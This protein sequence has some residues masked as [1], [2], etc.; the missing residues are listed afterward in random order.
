MEKFFPYDS[1]QPKSLEPCF[2][3]HV[4]ILIIC[5][6]F[7]AV[8]IIVTKT[9]HRLSAVYQVSVNVSQ[10]YRK[11]KGTEERVVPKSMHFT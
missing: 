11:R 4:T 3:L 6:L 1:T 9:Q 5:T 2:N 10:G 8:V 7:V